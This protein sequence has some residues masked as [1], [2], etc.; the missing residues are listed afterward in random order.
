MSHNSIEFH[1]PNGDPINDLEIMKDVT[2][3]IR[4]LLRN[5]Y[6]IKVWKDEFTISVEYD[7]HDIELSGMKLDWV[8]EE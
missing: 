3:T 5:N 4:I 7:F 6:D 8:E 2:E 1:N